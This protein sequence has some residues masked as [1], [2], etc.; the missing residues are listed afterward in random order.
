MRGEDLCDPFELRVMEEGGLSMYSATELRVSL[1][2]WIWR[3]R[4]RGEDLQL[5]HLPNVDMCLL[6]LCVCGGGGV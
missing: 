1:G 2:N 4:G 5:T 6:M 3:R